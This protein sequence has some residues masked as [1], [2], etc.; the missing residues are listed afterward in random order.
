MTR[1]AS[2]VYVAILATMLLSVLIGVATGLYWIPMYA[3]VAVLF[4]LFFYLSLW[5]ERRRSI[6]GGGKNG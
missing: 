5:I 6:D 1:N 3:F 4:V 2:N